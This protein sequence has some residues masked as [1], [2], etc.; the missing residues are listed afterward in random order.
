[1]LDNLDILI[2]NKP[3]TAGLRINKGI[4]MSYNLFKIRDR[5]S[6]GCRETHA[7]LCGADE[8]ILTTKHTKLLSF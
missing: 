1:M 6:I 4:L 8:K 7:S 5:R 2:N 3:K